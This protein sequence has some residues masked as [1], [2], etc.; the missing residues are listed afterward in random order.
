MNDL[1][2]YT[3]AALFALASFAFVSSITP[4]PNNLMLLYSGARFGFAR[5][6]PHWLGIGVGF[7][8]MIAL[9]CLGIATVFLRLP[10][11]QTAL[12]TIGCAYMLWLAFKLWKNGALPSA[13]TLNEVSN[14]KRARPL[15]FIQAALFQYVNPK[16][17]MMG[18]IV[19]AAYLPHTGSIWVNTVLA[20][21]LFILI[22]LACMST[23]I[24]GGAVLQKLMHLPVLARVVNGVIVVMTVYC[25]VAVWV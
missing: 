24:Q 21:L 23:W 9:C 15:T 17:W 18:L 19:P 11:A 14:A 2:Q 22:N 7:A 8:V 6:V 4:G 12:K 10:M 5:S 16:A 20:V 13:D 25:A 1:M 3:P